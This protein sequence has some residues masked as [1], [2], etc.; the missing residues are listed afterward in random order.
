MWCFRLRGDKV[1]IRDFCV[2][3]RVCVCVTEGKIK[4]ERLFIYG[5]LC[6]RGTVRVCVLGRGGVL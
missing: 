1:C 5:F 4:R 3:E 2:G 6:E